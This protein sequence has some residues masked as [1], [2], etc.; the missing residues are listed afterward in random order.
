MKKYSYDNYLSGQFDLK[1]DHIDPSTEEILEGL[2]ISRS[3]PS[4]S[5]KIL[6]GIPRFVFEENYADSFGLQWNICR[7]TQLDSVTGLSLSANRLWANTKWTPQE[8]K[9]KTILEVGSGAGRFTEVFL[10]AGAKV[11]S[12]DFS[13]AVNAN[14]QSNQ[15]KGDLFLFQGDLY[16]IPLDDCLFD[17]VFCYGVLQHT[18]DP[19]AAYKKI[20][21]KLRPGGK[22]S[23]DYYLKSWRPT[24]WSTPKYFWRPV[25]SRMNPELLFKLVKFYVPLYL[26]IDSFIKRIPKL[27]HL[28]S[29][30]IPVP[31]WN[32]LTLGLSDKQREEWAVLDTFDA[33][34]PRYDSPKT[35]KEVE[36]M[37]TNS[38]NDYVE[39]FYGSNGVVA[40]ITKRK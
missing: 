31:C 10:Q 9:G 39:A 17:F 28:L 12:F 30:L 26:P 35:L 11:V 4:K 19:D 1:I 2:L 8:I 32:Y 5:V 16:N 40:N 6:G 15:G 7:K 13:N 27:G 18:P 34:S 14:Y 20:F 37:V 21:Q 29:A 22:I 24:C 25:T 38:E 36:E 3:E 33:L 23:I